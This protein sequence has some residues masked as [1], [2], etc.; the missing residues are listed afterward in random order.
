MAG[1][2]LR[3][4]VGEL[5]TRVAGLALQGGVR[6]R[7]RETAQRVVE[8]RI[9]PRNSTVADGAIGGESAADVVGIGR[10]LKIGHVT[11]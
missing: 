4:Q 5:P 1:D 7:E 10:F 6:P 3:A 9:R 11:R 2:T 8:R